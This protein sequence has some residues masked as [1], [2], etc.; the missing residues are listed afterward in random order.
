M[1]H[2]ALSTRIQFP[3]VRLEY[4]KT[5]L[6]QTLNGTRIFALYTTA[7]FIDG[8]VTMSMT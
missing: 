8:L 3:M 4:P 2:D 7:L 6:V 1:S 5:R